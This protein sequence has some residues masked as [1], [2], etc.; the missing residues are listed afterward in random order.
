MIKIILSKF[1]I[2]IKGVFEICQFFSCVPAR[3]RDVSWLM[4]QNLG[5]NIDK[6]GL[7]VKDSI[8][9]FTC[10]IIV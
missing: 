6:I 9:G 7:K 3:G 2:I 5:K 4:A 1:T 8:L 10:E